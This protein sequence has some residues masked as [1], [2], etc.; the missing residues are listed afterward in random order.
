MSSE[1]LTLANDQTDRLTRLIK[2]VLNV[3]R[4]ESGQMP[5]SSQAFDLVALIERNLDQWHA[6]DTEHTWLG[7]GVF[8]VPSA[9][10]DSDRVDEVLMNLFDNTFK[11]S[12]TD[13]TIRVGVQVLE[14]RLVVN[15][16]DEGNGITPQEL[17][18]IFDKFHRIEHGDC[19]A[20]IWVW[21]RALYLSQAS[22]RQWAV[23]CGRKTRSGTV[24]LSFSLCLWQVTRA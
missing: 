3:A 14:N 5:L 1:I 12:R 21:T 9:R 11:Y 16:G 7:P 17:E 4:I 8:N 15:V 18:K 24:P 23:S 22:L 10:G 2:G 19:A 13:G 20:D 6:C